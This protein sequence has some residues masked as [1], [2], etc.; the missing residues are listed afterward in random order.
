M[1]PGIVISG[2]GDMKEAGRG[3]SLLFKFLRACAVP[4]NYELLAYEVHA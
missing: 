2:D 4:G 1:A 3:N